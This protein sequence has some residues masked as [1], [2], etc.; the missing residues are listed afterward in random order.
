[1][2]RLLFAATALAAAVLAGSSTQAQTQAQADATCQITDVS[3]FTDRVHVRCNVNPAGAALM[4][5]SGQPVIYYFAVPNSSPYATSFLALA[6]AAKQANK[7]LVITYRTAASN[8]PA[9]CG[10]GDCR[11][12]IA[13][14]LYY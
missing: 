1:M 6:T 12:A 13:A 5:Q 3:V 8:N 7:S 2:S 11:G 10:A 4:M 14:R 9:G